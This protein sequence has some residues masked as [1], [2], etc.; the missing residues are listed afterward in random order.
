VS[1]IPR[2]YFTRPRITLL[3]L[4]ATGL[5]FVSSA[6][7]ATLTV[8]IDGSPGTVTD[9]S[10]AIS[11]SGPPDTGRCSASF[12]D[13]VVQLVLEARPDA[14]FVGWS[15]L[16]G[17]VGIPE[18]N[19]RGSTNPCMVWLS[20]DKTLTA[21]FDEPGSWE[22]PECFI[23]PWYCE[24]EEPTCFIEPW[25]CG[26][27]EPEETPEIGRY[28]IV[29]QAW[30]EDPAAVAHE[31]VDKYGGQLGFI[32]EH[33]LKG[34][35]AGYP[36]NVV[37]DLENEPTVK[38]VEED[39]VIS[40][41]E[42]EP[43]SCPGGEWEPEPGPGPEP[44]KQEPECFIEPWFCEQESSDSGA[45]STPGDDGAAGA[46]FDAA[47][48]NAAAGSP[49]HARFNSPKLRRCGNRRVHRHGRCVRGRTVARRAC[50]KR[51]GRARH[52]CIRLRLRRLQR[53]ER[54]GLRSAR[55]ATL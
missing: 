44:P 27:E 23:E 40:L 36:T 4:C 42:W 15:G 34:Y 14:S 10:G 18:D 8:H 38:Y 54:L 33:A 19:C 55:R 53:I 11:C 5:L 49:G 17:E 35:S 9:S 31:Q 37:D 30:V 22:E 2:N 28:I 48:T 50:R 52:R 20:N 47:D 3:A 39:Q 21:A 45:K 29:F 25:E 46:Q 13:Q 1:D 26:E 32:Y 41:C 6:S 43:M 12:S 24:G 7:A 16:G 51:T